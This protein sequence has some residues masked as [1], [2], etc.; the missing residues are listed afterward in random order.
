MLR[1]LDLNTAAERSSVQGF[2]LQTV[3]RLSPNDAVLPQ[4]LTVCDM[5]KRGIGVVST[6]FSLP[7]L[8]LHWSV[9]FSYTSCFIH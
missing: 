6:P 2:T 7:S 8:I 5:V 1:S 4:V 3:A 9:F